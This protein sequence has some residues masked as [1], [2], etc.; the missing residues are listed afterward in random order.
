MD[1]ML[2]FRRLPKNFVPVPEIGQYS[3]VFIPYWMQENVYVI[4]DFRNSFQNHRRLS[5]QLLI[6]RGGYQ[7]ARTSSLKR[8]R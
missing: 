2:F 5:E 6:A 4:G 1:F 8:F 7:K 3:S